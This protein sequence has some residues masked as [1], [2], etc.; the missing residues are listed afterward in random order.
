MLQQCHIAVGWQHVSSLFLILDSWISKNKSTDIHAS[1]K[2][3]KT[4][5]SLDIHGFSWIQKTP[6]YILSTYGRR[7]TALL[8][9][10]MSIEQ[11]LS[12]SPTALRV[13]EVGDMGGSLGNDKVGRIAASTLDDSGFCAVD[14][15]VKTF[16]KNCLSSSS[17]FSLLLI[18]IL[19]L[20][21]LI[22]LAGSCSKHWETEH[23]SGTSWSVD[24]TDGGEEDAV[25]GSAVEGSRLADPNDDDWPPPSAS[26]L[27]EGD[28]GVS[29]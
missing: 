7:G 24:A 10:E 5:G 18:L 22:L 14:D 9:A 21:L 4:H 3:P 15:N 27:S 11:Y 16:A 28:D 13:G 19:L 6:T 17:S 8:N 1:I 12:A 26:C 25:A 23:N 20:L 29:S 2:F